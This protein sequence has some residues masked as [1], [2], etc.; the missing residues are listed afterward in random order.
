MTHQLTGR[1]WA[2]SSDDAISQAK[3]WIHA[4]PAL[5]LRTVAKVT[6]IEGTSAFD[7]TL[8]VS[9]SNPTSA[10]SEELLI[11]AYGGL[12]TAGRPIAD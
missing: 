3:E 7:V 10:M 8:S 2:D 6:A 12:G 5:R 11:A 4:E 9:P 1:F